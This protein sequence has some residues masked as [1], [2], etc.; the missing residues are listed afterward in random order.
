MEIC[1]S[2]GEPA[3][4]GIAELCIDTREIILDACCEANLDGWLDAIRGCSSRDRAQWVLDQTGIAV[5][6][7]VV[8]GDSI[9]WALDYGLRLGD[10]S[11]SE[12][13]EFIG[14]HHRHCD[15][16]VGWKFGA[17]VRNGSELVGVVTAGRPVSP[18][19][20]RQGCIEVN[21]VCVKD[22]SPRDLVRNACSMLYGYACREAFGRGYRRVITYTLE[23]E[24]GT[25]LRAA[26]FRPVARS[27]GG[28]WNR[29]GRP[30][31]DKSPTVPKVRW[32]RW[33]DASRVPRQLVL[34]LAV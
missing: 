8:A 31:T 34:P 22:H 32:E 17:A 21:R 27:R 33:S 12:A 2:C 23:S 4:F 11:F 16:P 5:R 24:R 7:V 20:A 29:P 25:S 10:I 18:V 6:D 14:I 19:L 28:S 3:R 30:R 15:P 1:C 13:R 26:G 9:S